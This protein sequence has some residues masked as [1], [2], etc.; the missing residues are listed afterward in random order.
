MR[1]LE[2]VYWLRFGFGILAALLCVSF[3]VVAGAIHTNLV[4]N[5]S[6]EIGN[7]TG[8]APQDWVSSGNGTEWNTIYARTGSRS[9]RIEGSNSSAEWKVTFTPIGGGNTYHI[10][11]YFFGQV[12]GGQFVLTVSWLSDSEAPI[13]E[14]N[15][16][17][18]GNYSQWQI[19]EADFTA[20][21]GAKKCEIGFKAIQGSGDLYGDDFEVRQTE[22]NSSFFNCASIALLVYIGSYYVLKSRF[23]TKVAKPQKILTAG[24]GIYL[25]TWIVVFALL[26]TMAAAL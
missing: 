18:T 2:T 11:G 21:A 26:Y 9:L 13:S 23:S 1:T 15:L 17:L 4:P 24:I 14:N 10:S 25:L 3:L 20:A 5:S 16:T 12:T 8:A 6:L 7:P 19:Q 22:P